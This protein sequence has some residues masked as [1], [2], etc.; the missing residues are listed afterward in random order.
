M[1]RFLFAQSEH[2]NWSDAIDDCVAQLGEL[3][4]QVGLGFIYITDYHA[5]HLKEALEKLKSL[6]QIEDWV[7]SVGMAVCASQKEYINQAAI[8]LMVTDITCE[9]YQIFT[10]PGHLRQSNHSDAVHVAVVHGDPRNDNVQAMMD[11]VSANIGNGYLVGGLTSADDYFYQIA[12]EALTNNV[13]G[14]VFD[15]SVNVI[16]G[17]TQG[18]SPIGQVHTITEAD[19]NIALQLDNRPTLDVLKQDIGETL[20]RDL[21]RISGY[22]FAGF[23]ISGSDTGDYTVRNLLGI[24]Q[25]SGAVAIG[26]YLQ[27]N[28]PM[29]FCKRD[30]STAI[31][32]LRNMLEKTKRRAGTKIKGALYFSCLGR[33][34]HMFG[35][36]HKELQLINDILGDIPLVGFYANGEIAGNRIYGYTGVLL[37]FL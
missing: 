13:S 26:E 5:E 29:M 17:L 15:E 10:S 19:I 18:C 3:P 8:V 25:E 2:P 12:G 37:L 1:D 14:V 28:S 9:H 6:T 27:V 22:I 36:Q 30:G 4:Q 35:E 32:E 33:G 34:V 11:Q 7:G 21:S 31:A 24:D 20:A 23:P 16:S